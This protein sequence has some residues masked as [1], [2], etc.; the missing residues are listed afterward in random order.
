M[1]RVLIVDESRSVRGLLVNMLQSDREIEIAGCASNGEQA[2]R[3]AKSETP[4]VMLMDIQLAGADGF[5]A[6]RK[7]MQTCPIPILIVSASAEADEPNKGFRAIEAGALALIRR[8]TGTT[9]P[10]YAETASEFTRTVKAMA[11]VKVVRRWPRA[12]ARRRAGRSPAVSRKIEA[13]QIRL[14][15]LGASTGGPAVLCSILTQLA[16]SYPVPI[17]IVQHM[18]SGFAPGFAVWLSSAASFPVEIAEHGSLLV[19]GRAYLAPDGFQLS[20]TADLRIALFRSGPEHGMCPSVSHLFRSIPAEI[21]PATM[22]V[23]LTGM[24]KD[25][26][27]ELRRLKDNGAITVVQDRNTSVVYGMPGE[28]LRHDAAQFVLNPNAIGELLGEI[29]LASAAA[30]PQSGI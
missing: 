3:V 19:G 8:P 23:L 14:V 24:G 6:I 15:L 12:E 20:V 1:I 11:E 13:A 26:A 27:Q 7:I 4:H 25:G 21:C 18:A 22:A 28:A 16:Q 30:Q 10:D 29:S 5:D 17:V 2:L 9:S